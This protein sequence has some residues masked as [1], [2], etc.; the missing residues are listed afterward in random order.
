LLATPWTLGMESPDKTGRIHPTG[1]I[2]GGHYYLGIAYDSVKDDMFIQNSWGESWA[3]KGIAK[4]NLT[5]W[6][7]KCWNRG[8]GDAIMAAELPPKET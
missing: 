4:I 8:K 5:E 6:A 1:S 3:D 7:N 2:V